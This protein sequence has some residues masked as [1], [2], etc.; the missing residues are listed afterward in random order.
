MGLAPLW[1]PWADLETG[2]A[3]LQNPPSPYPGH[4]PVALGCAD[5]GFNFFVVPR[6]VELLFRE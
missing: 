4:H 1:L 2:W 5:G 6:R 3:Y